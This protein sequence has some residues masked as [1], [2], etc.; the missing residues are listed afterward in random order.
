MA[1]AA[2]TMSA[3]DLNH[4]LTLSG[5]GDELDEF[6]TAF[7]GLLGRLEAAFERQRRF[8]GDAAHQLS[9]PL[10]VL[11]GQLEVALRRE[12][13][14]ADYR[15][16]IAEAHAQAV[17]LRQIVE[18]LLFLARPESD[19]VPPAKQPLEL[20]TWLSDQV[21]RWKNNP[22]AADVHL[23]LPTSS[24]AKIATVPTLLGQLFDNLLDN[25]CKYS[26][27]GTPITVALHTDADAV[28]LRVEDAGIGIGP[29]DLGH[30][31]EPFYRS[32][33]ARRL[34]KQGV[35]LGLA[36][37]RRVASA[38]GGTLSVQSQLGRGS[39]FELRLPK[40]TA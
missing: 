35:G 20:S 21:A 15:A 12:R 13:S 36:V 32:P 23:K 9:T 39:L 17:N 14:A 2:A 24:P 37:A 27:P 25:A 11:L 5:T 31:F 8:T 26:S 19:A 16:A 30:I 18:L 40:V 7:N 3:A 28:S 33:E 10:T 6:G 22:R 38:L 29:D 1:T 34:G 4:R